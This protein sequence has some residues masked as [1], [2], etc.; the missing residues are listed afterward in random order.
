MC[1]AITHSL[2]GLA[3]ARV[4]TGAKMPLRFWLAAAVLAAAPDLDV[5]GYSFGFG[6]RGE[7]SLWSHRGLTHSLPFALLTAGVATL[8]LFPRRLAVDASGVAPANHGWA[9]PIHRWRVWLV[10][11]CA[12]ASHGLTDMLTNGGSDIA[13]LSPATA[14]RAKWSFQPV[15]VSPLSIGRFFSQR[16]LDILLS[17]AKWVLLPSAAVVVV[18]E[19]WRCRG[20]GQSGKGQMAKGQRA[21]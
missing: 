19:V 8:L 7:S 17:E 16:G 9:S 18:V 14:W 10:L 13:L 12:M 6:L 5:L 15:E 4:G 11:A 2:V 20:K 1:S 3:V 21:R